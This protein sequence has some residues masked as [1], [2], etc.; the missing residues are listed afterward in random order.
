MKK[1]IVLPA[2]AETSRHLA[3]SLSRWSRLIGSEG[4]SQEYFTFP[5]TSPQHNTAI[6]LGATTTSQ[7]TSIVIV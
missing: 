4:K 5:H 2:A 3:M 6:A 7:I 1:K